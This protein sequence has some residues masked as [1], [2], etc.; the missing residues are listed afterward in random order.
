MN[1]LI[2]G[3]DLRAQILTKSL[4]S[5]KHHVTLISPSEAYC[6][7]V[8]NLTE[9]TAILGDASKPEVLTVAGAGHCD[10][11]IAMAEKD[12]DNLVICELA[13]KVFGVPQTIATVENP[14]NCTV[15]NRLGIDKV[16]CTAEAC[17]RMVENAMAATLIH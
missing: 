14:V 13:K 3:S 9:H 17:S 15:F 1:V 12:A 16:I 8:A 2:I 6:Q 7:Q 5:A 10:L 11:L 4:V